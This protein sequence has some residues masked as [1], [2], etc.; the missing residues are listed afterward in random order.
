LIQSEL[1]GHQN[2][3]MPSPSPW[4]LTIANVRFCHPLHPRDI[5]LSVCRYMAG[6]EATCPN[7]AW[8]TGTDPWSAGCCTITGNEIEINTRQS[9]EPDWVACAKLTGSHG[10]LDSRACA[11]LQCESHS[12]LIRRWTDKDQHGHP[13]T[14]CIEESALD[15]DQ[16]P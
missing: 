6:G 5:Y 7:S 9:L 3:R 13:Y 10:Q 1:T 14:C 2:G 15:L 12:G 4:P 8:H 16:V 11:R